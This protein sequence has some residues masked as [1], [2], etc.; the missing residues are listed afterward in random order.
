M[1]AQDPSTVAAT[2]K[3]ATEELFKQGTADYDPRAHQA[4]VERAHAAAVAATQREDSG[5]TAGS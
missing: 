3:A 1:T 2:S 4:A 5:S